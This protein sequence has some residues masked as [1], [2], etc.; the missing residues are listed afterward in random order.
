MHEA[1]D[2]QIDVNLYWGCTDPDD[3]SIL[4]DVYF[5]T[6]SPPAVV[7]TMQSES[8]YDPP[9]DFQFNTTYYWRVIA[10]D[11]H[12][13]SAAGREWY[14]TTLDGW[15]CGDAN[16]DM[17]LNIFDATYLINYLY[18]DGPPPVPIQSADVNQDGAVNIFDITYLIAYLYLDGPEP[19]CS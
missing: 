9:T 5:D 7:S 19:D 1:N 3:D 12:G 13:D 15:L 17:T 18:I 2:V 4:Y 16:G 11:S 10:W 14:F 8:F 6:M